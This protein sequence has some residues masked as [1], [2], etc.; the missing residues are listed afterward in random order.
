MTDFDDERQEFDASDRNQVRERNR[1]LKIEAKDRE[2]FMRAMLDTFE[3]RQWFAWL[4]LE[5]LGLYMQDSPAR[6]VA[7]AIHKEALRLTPDQYMVCMRENRH[8]M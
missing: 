5:K 7:I 4:L 6:G 3:G 1:E 2:S 8:K